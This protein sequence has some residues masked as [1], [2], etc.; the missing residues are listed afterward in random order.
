MMSRG[1]FDSLPESLAESSDEVPIKPA[2]DTVT[3]MRNQKTI[4]VKIDLIL[5]FIVLARY[6]REARHGTDSQLLGQCE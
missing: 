3:I 4:L 6:A 1:G 2:N 5:N